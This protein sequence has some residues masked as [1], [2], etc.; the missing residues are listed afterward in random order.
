MQ[1]LLDPTFL[2]GIRKA[3]SQH[4]IFR[5]IEYPIKSLGMKYL[6]G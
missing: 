4:L 3:I 5:I 1:I 6:E 2:L